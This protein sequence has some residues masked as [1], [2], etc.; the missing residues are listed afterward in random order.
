[1][2]PLP[3]IPFTTVEITGCTNEAAKGAHTAPRNPL[4]C[5]FI[6]YFTLY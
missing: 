6:S 3:V 1:M 2:I 5:F 4:S